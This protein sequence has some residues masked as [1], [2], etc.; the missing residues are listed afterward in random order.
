MTLL[1]TDRGHVFEAK[2]RTNDVIVTSEKETRFTSLFLSP[3]V[4]EGVSFCLFVRLFVSGS[5]CLFTTASL[6]MLLQFNNADR[7]NDKTDVLTG[8]L[9][10]M[11]VVTVQ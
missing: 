5:V 1:P 8:K 7:H 10:V 2:P 3:R 9:L 11:R 6:Q 4:T